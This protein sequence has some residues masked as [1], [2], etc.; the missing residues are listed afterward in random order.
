ME[1]FL[2]L[3]NRVSDSWMSPS[4]MDIAMDMTI[5]IMCGVGLFFLLLPF[6]KEYPVSSPPENEYDLPHDVKRGQKT[7]KKTVAGKRYRDGGKNMEETKTPSQPMKKNC[8]VPCPPTERRIQA[9]LPIESLPR[10]QELYSKTV[11]GYD[12]PNHLNP[13]SKHTGNLP[14]VSL[15]TKAIRP[16]SILPEHR[17][18]SEHPKEPQATTVGEQQGTPI[19]FLPSRK[20]TQ[21]QGQSLDH[22]SK[23]SPQLSQ[24][25]QP[26]IPNP[27]SC[28]CSKMMGPVAAGLP[29]KKDIAQ[30]DVQTTIKMGLG[31]GA[32]K[33][34]Y[35]LCNT[36]GKGLK[37]RNS[38]LRTDKLSDMNIAEHHSLL[39]SK[40]K[41]KLA[42]K[43]TE[44]PGKDRRRACLP[45]LEARDFT[46][47]GATAS[48]LP[49]FVYPSSPMCA[50]KAEQYNK[51]GRV[52]QNL[53]HQYPG[54]TLLE[55][56]PAARMKGAVFTDCIPEVQKTKRT[57]PPAASHGASKAHPDPFQRCMYVQRPA[58]YFQT[59]NP[60]QTRTIRGTGKGSLQPNMPAPISQ[61]E[62]L[63]SVR[64]SILRSKQ[65]K[66]TAKTC[67]PEKGEGSSKICVKN[68]PRSDLCDGNITTKHTGKR[69]NLKNVHPSPDNDQTQEYLT[70]KDT[71]NNMLAELQSLANVLFQILEN[72]EGDPSK[73]CK[74]ESL[75]AQQGDSCQSPE[76]LCDTNHSRGETRMSCGHAN[77][78]MYNQLPIPKGK[79]LRHGYRGIGDQQEPGLVDLRAC[80]PG[81]IRPTIGV[82]H[83]HHRSPEGHNQSLKYREIANKLQSGFDHKYNENTQNK[84]KGMGYGCFLS[85]KE[86]DSVKR[87]GNDYSWSSDAAQRASDSR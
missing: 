68:V 54:G 19:R 21:P 12:D 25:A 49:Q 83:Y 56:A 20:L 74:V 86:N 55:S 24:P 17:G 10:K 81:K 37:P 70:K 58:F 61:G 9:S 62:R 57:P 30:A 2:T 43:I 75:A 13:I 79:E 76:S 42:S 73:G 71:I 36:P 31:I 32:K 59:E 23:S 4:S 85:P 48:N 27:E 5:A 45:I 26:S 8:A 14:R 69:D 51:A 6:L 1:S 67:I 38:A 78:K 60:Q 29:L 84:I 47:P 18:T 63:G 77:P 72:T 82:G 87:W 80:G 66:D 41:R 16:A 11:R 33:V 40:T 64:P 3:M 7:S 35:L 53:H 65:L 50:S 39:D 46:P 52:L 44:L 28:K 34:A 15:D 22:Y